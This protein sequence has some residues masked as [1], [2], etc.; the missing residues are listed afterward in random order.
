MTTET[1]I[2]E[3]Y[4]NEKYGN[5]VSIYTD[6]YVSNITGT[7]THDIYSIRAYNNGYIIYQKN[8]SDSEYNYYSNGVP[9]CPF[10][11]GIKYPNDVNKIKRMRV[12]NDSSDD[13]FSMGF[14]VL[15]EDEKI[16][17]YRI[18]A[19]PRYNG[20][21]VF[22]SLSRPFWLTNNKIDKLVSFTQIDG[23]ILFNM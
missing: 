7:P 21:D 23:D 5:L 12:L 22:A 15:F 9:H 11:Y 18:T 13:D 19:D 4:I 1:N 8:P 2:I 10:D 16:V 14:I 20:L 3:K 17:I 6:K